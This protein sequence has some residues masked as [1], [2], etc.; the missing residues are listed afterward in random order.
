MTT[1]TPLA[2]LLQQQPSL[3]ATANPAASSLAGMD[4]QMLAQI[5]FQQHTK[6]AVEPIPPELQF[7]YAALGLGFVALLG[8]VFVAWMYRP[9]QSMAHAQVTRDMGQALI[10]QQQQ[11]EQAISTANPPQY[12]CNSLLGDCHFPEPP[13]ASATLTASQLNEI[14]NA[15]RIQSPPTYAA[16]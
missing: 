4:D 2:E 16:Y 5:Y 12:K 10:M 15:Q 9:V 1:Q 8:A 11:V 6:S 13:P 3:P 7:R 14:L